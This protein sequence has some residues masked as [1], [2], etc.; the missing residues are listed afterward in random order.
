LIY[1][2]QLVLLYLD[3][4]C[5]NTQTHSIYEFDWCILILFNLQSVLS[6]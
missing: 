5:M 6:F 3:N 2:K 4:H 1:L